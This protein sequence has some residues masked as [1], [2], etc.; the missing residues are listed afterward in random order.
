MSKHRAKYN[1]ARFYWRMTFCSAFDLA[2]HSGISYERA[3]RWELAFAKEKKAE[4]AS[5]GK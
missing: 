1:Q 2:K 5:N 4:G 3:V